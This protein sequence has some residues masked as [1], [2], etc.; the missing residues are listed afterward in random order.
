M[1]ENYYSFEEIKT[2]FKFYRELK[3]SDITDDEY[4]IFCEEIQVLPKEIVDRIQ[5]EIKFILLSA[6]PNK[7]NP[8]CYVNLEEGI[9]EEKKGIIVLT[10]YIFGASYYDKDGIKR[11]LHGIEKPCILHEVAHHIL[12]HI[13]YKDQRDLDEKERAAW[14]QAEKWFKQWDSQR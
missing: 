1:V 2:K 7:G 5:T 11:R 9:D 8:A 10:P 4:D 12:G 14:E 13:G 6:D 3:E